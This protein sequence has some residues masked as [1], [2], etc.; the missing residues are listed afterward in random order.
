VVSAVLKAGG[1]SARVLAR[2]QAGTDVI[3]LYD[4]RIVA[5][6]QEV[7]IRKGLAAELVQQLVDSLR[8]V[9]RSR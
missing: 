5:E 8:D 3:L 2:V 6:Y 7:L 9:A 1:V 4:D